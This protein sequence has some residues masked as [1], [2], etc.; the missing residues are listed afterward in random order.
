MAKKKDSYNASDIQS[1]SQHNHLLKR[2]A[3]TFGRETGDNENP[4]S[5]QKSVAIREIIDNA[6]DEVLG[7]YGDTIRVVY[8]EDDS[9]EIQDNGRG[10][11][12]DIG[13]DS[14]GK[15]ASGIYL[16]LGVIQSGGKFGTE[17][18]KYT[19]GLN[20]VG[21]SSTVHTSMRTDVTVFRDKKVYKLSFKDGTPGFFEKENDVNSKFTELDDYTYL[22]VEKDTRSKEE[23]EKFK[24]G[25]IV[26]TWLRDEVYA[27]NYPVNTA[28]LTERLRGTAFLIPG[29][30]IEVEDHINLIEDSETGETKVR[31]DHF[32][33]DGGI[34]DLVEANITGNKIG[35]IFYFKTETE[36]IEK[37][38]PVLEN[39]TTKDG[40]KSH[41]IINKDIK[42]VVPIEVAFAWQNNYDYNIESYV[43]TIRTR[44][45]GVHEVAFEKALV[46]AFGE[47]FNS[48]QGLMKRTDPKLMIDDF[49]EGL[50]SVVY[51]KVPEPSF[52][53]QSKDE[54]V[55]PLVQKAIYNK[56]TEVLG[57]FAKSN[58][59]TDLLK[60]VGEKVVIAARNRQSIQ[61][62]KAL[63]RK[64][65][66]IEGSGALPPK[67][68]DCEIT[69]TEDS[70][71]YIV[72]GDS[73]KGSLKGPRLSR[74]QALI[75]IRGKIIC[76][77]NNT[78]TKILA[79]EEVQGLI[80][81]IGAGSGDTFDISK[82]RY[83]RIFIG[84]D[85]DADGG[86]IS[87]LLVSLMW[88][89]FKPLVLEG[90]LYKINTPLFVLR[91]NPK[92]KKEVRHY[93]YTEEERDDIEDELKARKIKYTLQRL[94]GLGE[95]G[96]EV[97]RETAMDPLTRTVE[98]VVVKDPARV[99]EQL[100][101][102]FGNDTQMR[103]DWLGANPLDE[104]SNVD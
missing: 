96:F 90:R 22:K 35:D 99:E 46:S 29:M 39:T 19:S 26:R 33:F 89:L 93:A 4:F 41:K 11:P 45:G 14:T 95:G 71:L 101:L 64:K 55:S 21:S 81:A 6:V 68:V 24:T 104:F 65:N 12:I 59:N 42:R 69:G 50:V 16:C 61:E 15:P 62:A 83:G 40:I 13:N 63:N 74:Y 47:R 3:L 7:G 30:D 66:A 38:V 87:S 58:K 67:L 91:E 25:T 53:S 9:F 31:F 44:L 98:R 27:S 77:S 34:P 75:P 72:E 52:T 102:L 48:I 76:A 20:G 85:A 86:D 51:V 56:L 82:M 5:S 100:N 2:L 88:V 8:H 97:M 43:N 92:S 49:K 70:E 94:K 37:N 17:S 60:T 78:M 54:L 80:R 103:K 57:V 79:N 18:K 36:F 84:T 23:K 32:N 28:D 1:L 10:L 73:A